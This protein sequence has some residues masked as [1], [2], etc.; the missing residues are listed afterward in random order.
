MTETSKEPLAVVGAGYVGLVTAAW[1]AQRGHNVCCVE[2]DP[3][4]LKKL[5]DGKLPVFEPNLNELV[6]EHRARLSYAQSLEAARKIHDFRL[7]FVAV[8][9]SSLDDGQ[10]D[11]TH[12][13]AVIEQILELKGV[14]AVMKSTVPPGTGEQ[15]IRDAEARGQTLEYV[16]CPEF[17]QEG[18]AFQRPPD[19][20][21]I[22][23]R[24]GSWAAE[25]VRELHPD[26]TFVQERPYDITS[27]EAI[28]HAS[29]FHLAMRV[30]FANEIA[31]F[32]EQVGANGLEVLAAVGADHRIGEHFL[33]PGI[34]FGGSCFR[35]DIRAFLAVAEQAGAPSLLAAATL[36]V[37]NRQLDRTVAKLERALGGLDGCVI[38]VLG[39][40]FKSNTDDVRESR[41][42]ALAVRLRDAGASIRAC[43]EQPDALLNATAESTSPELR[44]LDHELCA[45]A[46]E[47]L[48]GADAGV[49]ATGS[50]EVRWLDWPEVAMRMRG[51]LILDGRNALTSQADAIAGAGL[52]YEGIGIHSRGLNVDDDDQMLLGAGR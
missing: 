42:L 51:N 33:E 21:V 8:P 3:A 43:D 17:L 28:K 20:V 40:A 27:A 4:K 50:D 25:L 19:R 2:V 30:S 22:G 9:T 7:A 32:S 37:N 5:L 1:Y 6:Q 47:A 16:S 38:A 14:A 15:L 35:K 10:A 11:L 45:S 49:L 26:A 31:N 24:P 46:L 41:G 52:R 39:A 12:V 13:E 34:G 23:A 18:E 29:N 36:D 44:L 48:T